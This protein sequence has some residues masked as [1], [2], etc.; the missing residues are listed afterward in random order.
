MDIDNSII[1]G[2]GFKFEDQ[3]LKGYIKSG[4]TEDSCTIS[5]ID[6]KERHIYRIV[7]DYENNKII[8]YID[9]E[10]VGEIEGINSY[11]FANSYPVYYLDLIGETDICNL[12][13]MNF[14]LAA[15]KPA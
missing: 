7:L 8:F 15:T 5:G 9:G 1:S 2:W 12:Y 11:S 10:N 6:V 14:N 3:V 4:V 13:S